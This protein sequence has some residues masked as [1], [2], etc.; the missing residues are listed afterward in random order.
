MDNGRHRLFIAKISNLDSIPVWVH[1]RHEEWQKKRVALWNG[2][3][4]INQDH[5]DYRTFQDH[6]DICK[7]GK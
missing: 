5:R 3:D 2:G 6:P 1:V 7:Q 4:T